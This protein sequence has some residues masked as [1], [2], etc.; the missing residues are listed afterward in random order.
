M[1]IIGLA[2]AGAKGRIRFK[3]HGF[4]WRRSSHHFQRRN[5]VRMG[6]HWPPISKAAVGGN[7]EAKSGERRQFSAA[8]PGLLRTP[9]GS[10]LP[11]DLPSRCESRCRPE[12]G[13]TSRVSIAN[14]EA[15]L[16]TANRRTDLRPEYPGNFG[17]QI[18]FLQAGTLIPLRQG[19]RNERTRRQI[20]LRIRIH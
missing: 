7:A 4:H 18:A 13:K 3:V 20:V 5:R 9:G 11:A 10:R 6:T 2:F 8:F 1:D 19:Q 12:A 15:I 16:R 17:T 14:S